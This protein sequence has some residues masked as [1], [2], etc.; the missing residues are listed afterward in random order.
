M[1]KYQLNQLTS[2]IDASHVYGS[3][4]DLATRFVHPNILISQIHFN[5]PSL[6]NLT[7]DYGRLRE[8]LTYDY[9][10]VRNDSVDS[11]KSKEIS[12]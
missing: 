3:T 4:D 11:V 9:G 6:R 1:Y 8:G 7:N 2:Y 10:K 12:N 5:A